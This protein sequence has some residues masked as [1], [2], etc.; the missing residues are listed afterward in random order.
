MGFSFRAPDHG[1]LVDT[2]MRKYSKVI[3]FNTALTSVE[4][5]QV[6]NYLKNKWAKFWVSKL[7]S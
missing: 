3:Y 6:M 1:H 4:R 2:K 5:D 7:Y